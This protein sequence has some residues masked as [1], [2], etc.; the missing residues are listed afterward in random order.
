MMGL[1]HAL[2]QEVVLAVLSRWLPAG[3]MNELVDA[4]AG[5]LLFQYHIDGAL[6]LERTNVLDQSLLS[7]AL[8][9]AWPRAVARVSSPNWRIPLKFPFVND[10]FRGKL[11]RL[12]GF[13][14]EPVE[15]PGGPTLPFQC[16]E[17]AFAGMN[18]YFAPA[19]HMVLDMSQPG[20]WF[21]LPGGAS[22]RRFGAGYG[23]GVREWLTGRFFPLGDATGDAPTLET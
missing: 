22:E 19:F 12:F 2:H 7:E 16:R 13:D 3:L 14:T 18:L 9:S 23:E 20:A 10:Y 11:P 17:V 8:A 6:A 1:F 4:A 15:P 21:H 5:I